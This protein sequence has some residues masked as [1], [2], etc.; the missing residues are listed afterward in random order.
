MS[1]SSRPL[2]SLSA[3]LKNILSTI[4]TRI[5]VALLTLIMVLVN[6]RYL[7]AE[8]VGTIG[9]IILAIAILQLVSNLVGGGA[10]VYLVPRSQLMKL[11]LP[12]CG[13][14]ILTSALGAFLL[15]VSHLI[16]TGYA[17]HV[18]LLALLLSLFTVNFMVLMGQERIRAYNIISLLQVGILFTVLIFFF[19]GLKNREVMA[20]L[21]GLYIS[22]AFAFLTSLALIFP[23]FKKKELSG[24]GKVIRELVH[25]GSVMQLGNILQF[26]NYR[27]SYYF[28]EFF[29]RRAAVGVY[30][31]GVQLSESIWLI[32][33]SIHLVQYTRIS[34][35]KDENYAAK[36]TLNLVKISFILTLLSLI[37]IMVV[38]HVF[39]TL[40]FK[41]E[42]QQVPVIML[43]L[44]AGI[45][46]FSVSIILSPYFSG[47]GKPVHNTIS[48]AIGL[49]FTLVL[50]IFLIPWLGLAGAGLAATFSYT[51]ATVYQFIVFIRMT[52]V[53]PPDF[54]LRKADILVI[55]NA[56]KKLMTE[57]SGNQGI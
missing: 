38:L 27:L 18:F 48:A 19:F 26:F 52:K 2:V 6:A 56:V 3:M 16:P 40:I 55:V 57:R 34:N 11:F 14:A 23:S 41:P 9:L 39:F 25:L 21:Y 22:Y 53:K 20:Y 45:L 33:K 35:E 1:L 31:V 43:A 54:L 44:S 51:A 37:L 10:L 29:L 42:F 50:C 32:A 30:S 4:I 5:L 47:M 15:N 7:G 17:N 36:L 46:T 49:V 12:S 13:W 28:I 8:K 24:S